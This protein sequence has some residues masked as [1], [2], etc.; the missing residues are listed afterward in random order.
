LNQALTKAIN[1]EQAKDPSQRLTLVDA[2]QI[3][4]KLVTVPSSKSLN[5]E[6]NGFC[7]DDLEPLTTNICSN[8]NDYFFWDRQHPNTESH[9]RIYNNLETVFKQSN[10]I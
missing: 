9:E 1:D 7:V 6:P 10:L 2:D 8:P 4:M 3:F 5:W